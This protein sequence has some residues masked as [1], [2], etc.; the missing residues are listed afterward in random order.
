VNR[1][2][3]PRLQEVDL[4]GEHRRTRPHRSDAQEVRDGVHHDHG[5]IELADGLLHGEQVRLKAEDARAGAS[6]LQQTGVH[7]RLRSMPT[8]DMFR[9]ISASDSSKAK[10]M[11]RS[12][13]RQV[14]SQNCAATVDL[15][16]PAV[17][18]TKTVL[19]L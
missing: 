2:V 12:P 13:L 14:A 15:P 16:V 7:P 3:T 18:L 6:E 11:A 10:Y 17:P 8:E 4:T 5:R 19:P 1:A 9:T